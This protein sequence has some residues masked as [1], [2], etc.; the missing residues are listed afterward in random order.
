MSDEGI[1]GNPAKIEV[2]T[3]W[4][5]PTNVK[6]VLSFLGLAGYYRRFVKEF[7]CVCSLTNEVAEEYYQIGF[8]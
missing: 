7:S 2:V 1:K 8:G 5:T 4:T 3:V 6:E